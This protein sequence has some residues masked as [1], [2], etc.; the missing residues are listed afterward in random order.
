MLSHLLF[1]FFLKVDSELLGGPVL[2]PKLGLS[3]SMD[4]SCLLPVS[5]SPTSNLG[6][7]PQ[8]YRVILH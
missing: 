1:Y 8:T 3:V 5:G 2:S 4:F 6:N 7:L